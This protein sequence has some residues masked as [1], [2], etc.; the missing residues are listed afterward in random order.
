MAISRL[1]DRVRVA[2]SAELGG[3]PDR[4]R[5]APIA[6]LHRVL[7]DWFP[8]A[9]RHAHAQAW[10]GARPMSPDGPPVIGAT[11]LPGV[12]V[13]TGHG[14]SGWALACGSARLLADAVAGRDTGDRRFALFAAALALRA[15]MAPAMSTVRRITFDSAA[16]A[17]VR[18]RRVA[19]G[20]GAGGRGL[21]TAQPDAARRR[22][23]RKT[24]HRAG[25]A[26]PAHLDCRRPRQQRWR[27]LTKR[28]A[29]CNR[30]A[31]RSGSP[32]SAI[33]ARHSAD[34]AASLAR[35]QAAG[36]QIE[37]SLP[38]NVECDLAIDAIFGLGTARAAGGTFADALRLFN[39]L[40][41]PRLAVDLPSG[42]DS[43]H[44]FVHGET[45]AQATHTLAL[46]TL[47]PGQFTGHGREQCGEV[48]FDDLG[49]GDAVARCR[50]RPGWVV[51]TRRS[52]FRRHGGTRAT[53]ATSAT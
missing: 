39:R 37:A 10:K 11:G 49:S 25:A 52:K 13:N 30:P 27:W 48:W 28:R 12:W 51:P 50:R 2:G 18:H 31:G 45:G 36:V 7:Q 8:N 26:W 29:G 6:T 42:L 14:S 1:G 15:K 38:T 23:H 47:K 4:L 53:R 9:A 16:V 32:R 24:G 34:A 17:P 33:V 21:C 40:R 20:R 3:A 44:G 46:L 35:A 5:D 19:P 41:G 22:G 43:D